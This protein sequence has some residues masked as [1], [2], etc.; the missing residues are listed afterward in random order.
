[1]RKPD[2]KKWLR[3]LSPLPRVAGLEVSDHAVRFVQLAERGR[4]VVV[5][6]RMP[7][8]VMM[9]GRI[10][11]RQSF[12]A[13]LK[14]LHKKVAHQKTLHVVLSVPA[15]IVYTQTFSI[16]Y[17][18]D[19]RLEEAAKLNLQMLS[20]MDFEKVYASYQKV[21]EHFNEGGQIELLGAFAERLQV[22]EIS[23]AVKEAGFMPV[24]VEFPALALARVVAARPDAQTNEAYL[25]IHVDTDGASLGIQ[26]NGNMSFNHFH[27][28]SA[29]QEEFGGKQITNDDFK[30]FL[31]REVQKVMNFY[32]GKW[33]GSVQGIIVIASGVGEQIGKT[34]EANFGLPVK[35]IV[36]KGIPALD[37]AYFIAFGA[38]LRGLLPRNE[39]L[40]ITLTG[41]SVQTQYREA[42]ILNFIS[43]WR[44]IG[45]VAMSF[46]IV[47]FGV[48][49]VFLLRS[50][51]PG[52]RTELT[53]EDLALV[54]SLEAEAGE[55]NR[56]VNEALIAS[57]ESIAWS[58]FFNE[59][60]REAGSDM[61]L[62]KVFIE[63]T[64]GTT[65]ATLGGTAK[66]EAVVFRFRDTLQKNPR[67]TNIELPL[68]AIKEN[69]TG[70]VDFT[71]S[72]V[73]RSLQF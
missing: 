22:D 9:A 35:K 43:L 58:K 64:R 69:Q 62:S 73:V 44:N 57:K 5:S 14:E 70:T 40:L 42:R 32:T 49:D 17:L 51:T 67:L 29:I 60:R 59:M 25:S 16:P 10:K 52:E 7:P 68:E 4:P 65:F 41:E 47:V 8:Q 48:A 45:I 12:I 19:D 66:E 13:T 38:G 33:G 63:E 50:V 39:D 23:E 3:L 34:I 2:F 30:S 27:S 21:G 31:I 24:A 55:F 20:P 37:P 28:W 71:I 56:V 61:K 53:D 1:M 6:L 54:E 15:H 36:A 11:N 18:P 46:I 26:R 72:F